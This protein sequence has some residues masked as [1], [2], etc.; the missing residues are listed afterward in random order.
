MLTASLLSSGEHTNIRLHNCPGKETVDATVIAEMLCQRRCFKSQRL[1]RILSADPT[2]PRPAAIQLVRHLLAVC[3]VAPEIVRR[4]CLNA[5]V[6][7]DRVH[8]G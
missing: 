6:E 4:T 2:I 3:C 1:R 5:V 7:G 8:L